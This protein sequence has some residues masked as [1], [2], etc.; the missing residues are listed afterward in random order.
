LQLTTCRHR[1][2]LR[3]VPFRQ[4]ELAQT[5]LASV[6]QIVQCTYCFDGP[7]R[8]AWDEP[9]GPSHG[10]HALYRAY[11]CAD[12]GTSGAQVWARQR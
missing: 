11:R 7:G 9:H 12:D 8:G 4:V 10:E 3:F 6:G 1:I 5:S 2:A